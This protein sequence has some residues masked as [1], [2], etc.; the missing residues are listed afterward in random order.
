MTAKKTTKRDSAGSARRVRGRPF[1]KGHK[2]A[3]KKGQSGNPAGTS[4]AQ[5]LSAAYRHALKEPLPDGSGRTYADLIAETLRHNAAA[6]DVAAARELADRSEGKPKQTV[7][8]EDDRLKT[9]IESG[10]AA[11]VA[12]G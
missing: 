1:E 10:L 7:T 4:K 8:V 11:L 5:T 3:W 2:Y 12:T 9:V 6:G